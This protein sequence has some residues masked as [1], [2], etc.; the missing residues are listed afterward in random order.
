MIELLHLGYSV[1]PSVYTYKFFEKLVGSDQLKS[2]I[3]M[4]VSFVTKV[5][6]SK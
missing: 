2:D 1:K 3:I 4:K 5:S 6:E